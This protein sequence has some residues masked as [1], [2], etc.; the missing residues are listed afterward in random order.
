MDTSKIIEEIGKYLNEILGF[1]L[2]G[3]VANFLLYVFLD[4][5]QIPAVNYKY[6]L[7]P[8]IVIF[9]S[10]V[11]GY[12]I[13]GI[14]LQRDKCI[15]YFFNRLKAKK[16]ILVIYNFITRRKRWLRVKRL[17]GLSINESIKNITKSSDY[18]FT[19]Q[20]LNLRFPLM[21]RDEI[22][23]NSLRNIAMSYCPESDQKIYTFMFRSELCNHLSLVFLIMGIWILVSIFSKNIFNNTLLIKAEIINCYYF[24]IFLILGSHFFHLT[25]KRFH[26]IAYKIVFS[27]FNAKYN[28]ISK[29][30]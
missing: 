10:Y 7:Y 26:G 22:N 24:P 14:A 29:N 12:L 30:V 6:I 28:P 17:P 20:Y 18:R 19:K 13:Y 27:I 21:V 4:L 2:P 9:V 1:L 25:R 16:A 15:R 8:W 23:F 3:L 11:E 5:K